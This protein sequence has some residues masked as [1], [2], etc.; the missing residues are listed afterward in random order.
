MKRPDAIFTDLDG[1]LAGPDKRVGERDAA[2][3][4]RLKELGI[5]VIPCT[6]RPILGT[7]LVMEELGLP[8]A[9]CSNGGCCYDFA[10]ERILFATEMDHRVA[11]RLLAW[12]E[13]EGVEYLL[14]APRRIFRSR[15]AKTPPH[16]LLRGEEDGGVI[17]SGTPLEGERIL[18]ILAVLC[19]EG[20]V[21]RRG[22]ERFAPEE[23][24]ICSS[25][26]YYVDFNPP[27]V[28]KG[29]GLRRL[30][31]RM[32][33]DPA[34]IFAMGDNYNDLSMLEQA[35]MSAAPASA[36]PE[37]RAAAGFVTAPNGEDPLAA[38]LEHYWPGLV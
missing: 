2:A 33:W 1:T 29:A 20:E 22:R 24:T 7:L 38:A 9:I 30:A 23:L 13:E 35:G 19:D 3:I 27:G 17:T 21:I 12:L 34:N 15:G 4:R 16:Y 18:K 5:P 6:G 10:R 8:L 25:E 28:N 37:A 36:I 11:H 14:H 26:R 31:E 32:G